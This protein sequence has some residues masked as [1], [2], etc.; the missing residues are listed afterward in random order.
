MSISKTLV[1]ILNYHGEAVLWP[2][3]Q[4]VL[5][6]LGREDQLM[7][8]DNGGEVGLMQRVKSEWPV[9]LQYAT[10][11]NQGFAGGMNHGL[12]YASVQG[13][14]AVWILNNDT[15][16]NPGAL[17][18]LREAV[19]ARPGINLFSPVIT[20]QSGSVWFAGGKINFWSMR[21]RHI[22]ET[23]QGEG[24]FTTGFLTGCALFIPRITLE[25]VGL[26][27][28]RYFLYYEDADYSLRTL[29]QGGK[30]WVVP[31]AQVIHHEASEANP[32]KL[33]W[34]VR[35]GVVFFLRSS[36]KWLLPWTWIFLSLRR[37]KNWLRL[38][39]RP[40]T[41]ARELE[42]AYTDALKIIA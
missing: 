27:D 16:V 39:F 22:Q 41:V 13:F 34:L 3:I 10:E 37:V 31:G 18:A 14:D 23:S 5:P 28:E 30:L 11:S 40:T 29:H 20:N 7:V 26:L 9:I 19:E 17:Q 4:S 2:C 21:T 6:E 1:V 33:Y 36:P 38:L 12:Q 24:P 8:V 25:T 15:L 32:A 42:R 35:S